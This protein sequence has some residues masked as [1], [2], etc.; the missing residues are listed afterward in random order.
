MGWK[1]VLIRPIEIPGNNVIIVLQFTSC[2]FFHCCHLSY[3]ELIFIPALAQILQYGV[4]VF[5]Y[6]YEAEADD[7][8]ILD[9]KSTNCK[10]KF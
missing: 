9:L 4:C 10:N 8:I 3:I 2:S 5:G 6:L 7:P 1:T